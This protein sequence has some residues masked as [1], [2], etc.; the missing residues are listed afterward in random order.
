L[1]LDGRG[2]ARDDA[3]AA[4]WTLEAAKHGHLEA[5]YRMGRLYEEGRGVGVD[6]RQ[7]FNWYRRAAK[8]WYPPAQLSLGRMYERGRGTPQNLVKAEKWYRK[9]VDEGLDE[10]R[11][12]LEGL[13][14]LDDAP[15][16]LPE[17]GAAAAAAATTDSSL[18]VEQTPPASA[19]FDSPPPAA[20]P[21]P[22]PP[23]PTPA[24]GKTSG[25]IP[26]PTAEAADL[27]SLAESGDPDAQYDLARRYA[28]GRGVERDSA[29]AADWYHR[30]AEQGLT[31]AWYRLGFLYMDGRGLP[32]GRDLSQAYLW[33]SLC[34]E[35]GI[36]DAA[37]WRDEVG[38]K[39]SRR[40]REES[41]RLIEEWQTHPPRRVFMPIANL[42]RLL[43]AAIL[44]AG[45]VTGAAAAE[46]DSI[47]RAI[48]EGRL[49]L[50]LRYRYE[51]VDDDRFA[52]EARAN[53][54]RLRMGWTTA[55][56]HGLIAMAGFSHTEALGSEKYDSTR[57]GKDLPIVADP[58]LTVL[59]RAYIGYVGLDNHKF[60][61]G[62]QR[63]NLDN[64]RYVGAVAWRQNEQTFDAFT[65]SGNPL[66]KFDYFYGHVTRRN[67]V[68]GLQLDTTTDLFNV[69]YKF[70]A[71]KLVGYA[72][73]L[74]LDNAPAFSQKTFGVRFSG[75]KELSKKIK[76]LYT[77][78]YADQSPYRDGAD[79]VDAD[80][81]FVE[82]GAGF[83]VAAVKVGYE[84]LGGNG[85]YGFSTPYATLHVFNGRVDKFLLTPP[86]G[87]RDLYVT[88]SG[89]IK[90]IQLVLTLHRFEADQGGARY[91]N[92]V[93][94][95]V[96][97]WFGDRYLA[98]LWYGK[99]SAD[100]FSND[101]DKVWFTLRLRM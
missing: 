76:L 25:A 20:T 21:P 31:M 46:D 77:G 4:R 45:A 89:K 80:Y 93:N 49:D 74:D 26:P 2:V 75:D 58:Q 16:V 56:W 23:A 5:Q 54:I 7:A 35:E 95:A 48:K 8:E 82:V 57:N 29:T 99:Y 65:A 88:G 33:F 69:S 22:A 9:A 66:D 19:P 50:D 94:F 83:E 13:Y 43:L 86:D 40:Q 97:R 60:L 59:A 32:E 101:T 62:R 79:S 64:Q 17:T 72:Y 44:V 36:G 11:E 91:G 68:N 24:P 100:T 30:A 1:Y 92:E 12:A 85:Q 15:F 14:R 3:E 47:I 51:G 98:G 90:K 52:D 61:L 38:R 87:L 53:T 96:T 42:H 27:V 55:P 84:M 10:A 41:A 18:T 37:R 70:G 81:G 6:E 34:A 39:M 67:T 28:T 63:I 73:L 71:G 78:E